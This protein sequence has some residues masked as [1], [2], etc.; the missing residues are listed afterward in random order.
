MFGT[1]FTF[2]RSPKSSGRGWS[3]LKR[4]PRGIRT[5]RTS[6][7]TAGFQVSLP[8][9][10][11]SPGEPS[12]SP[13]V[14]RS[15]NSFLLSASLG[16]PSGWAWTHITRGSSARSGPAPMFLRRRPSTGGRLASGA[17]SFRIECSGTI[18]SGSSVSAWSRTVARPHRGASNYA[19]ERP[20]KVWLVG[21]TGA[22]K[23][24]A[25]AAPGAALPR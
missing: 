2:R 24:F 7:S 10:R 17:P 8:S 25:P 23:Q 6:E 11:S 21:A 20:V 1:S 3:R 15:S 19:L 9:T 12:A 13:F 5:Q 22:C 4:G 14:L 18:N 16:A